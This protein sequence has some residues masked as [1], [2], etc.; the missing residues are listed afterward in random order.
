[1]RHSLGWQFHAVYNLAYQ[2]IYPASKF[3]DPLSEV[4][5][6]LRPRATL[7]GA[8]IDAFGEWGLSFRPRGDL[9]F[10]WIEQG[11]CQLLRP[12]CAPVRLRR[13]DFALIY[14]SAPFTLASDA[15]VV[16]V[17]S[18][19]VVAATKKI[20]LTLGSGKCHPI[21][22]HAGKFLMHEANINLLASLMP[23]LVLVESSNVSSSRVR[24]LLSMNEEEARQPGPASRFVIERLVE[25]I[26]VEILR[27]EHLRPKDALTGLLA[28][29]ADSVTR[30]ALLAMHQNLAHPW[31]IDELA[32]ICKVSR[33]TFAARFRVIMGAPPMAYLLN[34]R[35]ALAKDELMQG[36]RSIGEIAYAIGFQSSS[37][38]TTSFTR[39]VGCSPKRYAQQARK[40]ETLE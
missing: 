23:P 40:I 29:L 14:T 28:G 33:S 3:V 26:L 22:L 32:E 5:R 2:L 25:L 6:L 18:E 35:M 39:M 31:T 20:R 27:V 24:S 10:C 13:G 37:A 8:G 36:A 1:V 34:W 19:T 16:P 12:D 21:I 15:S 4:I 11:E 30:P 17:D 7:F 38:F 9:L